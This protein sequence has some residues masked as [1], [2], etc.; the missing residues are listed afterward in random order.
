MVASRSPE[1]KK[2]RHGDKSHQN[3]SVV[4]MTEEEKM[5]AERMRRIAE[6]AEERAMDRM[7]TTAE[8]KETEALSSN[9]KVAE[10]SDAN[11]TFM[12]KAAR[13]KLALERL[14]AK[15]KTVEEARA[16]NNRNSRHDFSREDDRGGDRDRG[17][18]D[19]DRGGDRD[20][21]R[22]RDR[23]DRDRD[24][25]RGV[26]DRRDRDRDERRDRNRKEERDREKELR[27]RVDSR[28]ADRERE[29][30]DR[31]REKELQEIKDA[32]LGGKKLKKK[33][34]RPS[35]KFAKM[36]QFDWDA[37]ED[38]S[39]DHNPLYQEK[40]Q[41]NPLL[42]RGYIA[43]TDMREQRK[44][45]TFMET[46]LQKRQQEALAYEFQ[47]PGVKLSEKDRKKKEDK[48][49]LELNALTD[50]LFPARKTKV[51]QGMG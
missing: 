24:Q 40:C 21:D 35:E 14:E 42:G 44:S 13:E 47:R 39:Q 20:R 11:V 12:S 30:S 23:R 43:G 5:D 45:N 33:V 46:L 48:Y 8:N 49:K 26:R 37:S 10:K 16:V 28:R 9:R 1:R 3:S 17:G 38:N 31:E 25:D 51:R 19:R 22:D 2:A 41:V 50:Q 27:G 29:Q 15:R 32:Y 36:F 6:R 4:P 34:V 18:R 7:K